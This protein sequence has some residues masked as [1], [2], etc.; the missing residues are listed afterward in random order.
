MICE[1]Q[2][3]VH[4]IPQQN[5]NDIAT[6]VQVSYASCHATFIKDL[7]TSQNASHVAPHPLKEM[8]HQTRRKICQDLISSADDNRTFVHNIVTNDKT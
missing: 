8:L 1:V 6:T 3:T 7:M 2:C 5:V 4:R